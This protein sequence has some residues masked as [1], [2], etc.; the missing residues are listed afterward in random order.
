VPKFNASVRCTGKVSRSAHFKANTSTGAEDYA[1][2]LR[3]LGKTT[4]A[5]TGS[6]TSGTTVDYLKVVEA[7]VAAPSPPPASPPP[8]PAK[9]ATSQN[10]SGYHWLGATDGVSG[11]WTVPTLDCADTS[12]GMSSDWVGVNGWEDSSGLFQ[13]GVNDE[14]DNGYQIDWAWFTDE[15]EGYSSDQG[16]ANDVFD[17][18]SAGDVI[19]AEVYLDVNGYWDYVITDLTS[20][21][22]AGA[23]VQD[24]NDYLS[25]AAGEAEWIDEDT[26]CADS[27]LCW[28]NGPAEV[29]PFPNFG[30]VTFTDLTLA[31]VSGS[32]TL[33]YSDALEMIYPDGSPEVLPSQPTASSFTVT[34]ESDSGS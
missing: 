3:V 20:G 18:V 34:Y 29:F 11:E 28:W 7:G 17:D 13:T 27:S 23:E 14:C 10:W 9:P 16:T 25:G 6:C 26:G 31:P 24:G 12:N 32:W 2:T 30:S 8:P 33:P 1:L 5:T 21:A 4:C 15:A 19:S 22:T